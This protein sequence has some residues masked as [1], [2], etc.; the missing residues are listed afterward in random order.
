MTGF[1]YAE[2]DANDI[3]LNGAT[4][5]LDASTNFTSDALDVSN[6]PE[7]TI[8][9]KCSD[10]TTGIA[11]KYETSPDNSEWFDGLASIS[12][13]DNN[14]QVVNVTE[15]SIRYIRFNANNTN[16]AAATVLL[17]LVFGGKE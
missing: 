17:A 13:L 9:A 8:Y 6:Y 10:V 1:K 16:V 12:N 15:N 2:D 11:T 14:E 5:S 3:V 4:D 7:L